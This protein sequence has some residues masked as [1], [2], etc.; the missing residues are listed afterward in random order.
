MKQVGLGK[1]HCT[2][3]S[4]AGPRLNLYMDVCVGHERRKGMMGIKEKIEKGDLQKMKQVSQNG[5]ED[6]QTAVRKN[7]DV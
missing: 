2:F 5:E 4:Y 1:T 7:S 3:F 6:G